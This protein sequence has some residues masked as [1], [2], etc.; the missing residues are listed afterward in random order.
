MKITTKTFT[1]T[2]LAFTLA[3]GAFLPNYSFAA[4]T[5]I[6][7]EANTNDIILAPVNMQKAIKSIATSKL[8]MDAYKTSISTQESV[9]LD[10]LPDLPSYQQI[11]RDHASDYVNNLSSLLIERNL[12]VSA[13][14]TD[15]INY[16]DVLMDTLDRVD[17]GDDQASQDFLSLLNII[18]R[19]IQQYRD[20]TNDTMYSFQTY[21]DDLQDDHFNFQY[22]ATTTL[23]NL[24]LEDEKIEIIIDQLNDLGAEIKEENSVLTA[25]YIEAGVV[26]LELSTIALEIAAE[27]VGSLL[28]PVGVSIAIGTIIYGAVTGNIALDEKQERIRELNEEYEN[29][30][31]G[32]Q[33]TEIQAAVLNDIQMQLNNFYDANDGIITST[34]DLYEEW[35]SAYEGIQN[36]KDQYDARKIS[37]DE[38]RNLLLDAKESWKNSR[39]QADY[40]NSQLNLQTSVETLDLNT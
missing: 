34:R 10:I 32:L 26:G 2:A 35:D 30:W 6:V 5:A 31:L 38:I 40:I 36:L 14:A 23:N 11:A 27:G 15:F 9:R 3:T 20:D 17:A 25:E 39:A 29:I 1:S 8:I 16:Y 24:E 21:K 18:Q 28:G 7:A 19:E 13:F 37:T 12:D 4:E 22:A 33:G